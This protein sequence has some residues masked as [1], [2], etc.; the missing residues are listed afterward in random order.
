MTRGGSEGS[1][2]QRLD[3][4]ISEAIHNVRNL[5]LDTDDTARAVKILD[6]VS[7]L[8]NYLKV[9]NGDVKGFCVDNE[10]RMAKR[11]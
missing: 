5:Q 7:L 4:M 2:N 1:I 9:L 6:Q 11:N 3:V 8:D 10:E